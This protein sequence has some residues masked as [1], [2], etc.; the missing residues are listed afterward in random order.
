MMASTFQ[1]EA[2]SETT[3]GNIVIAQT[4]DSLAILLLTHVSTGRISTPVLFSLE[5]ALTQFLKDQ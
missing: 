1:M 3:I 4:E 5:G 2:D